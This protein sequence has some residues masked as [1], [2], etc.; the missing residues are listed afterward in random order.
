MNDCHRA[1]Y[2]GMR[3]LMTVAASIIVLIAQG[4]TV[5]PDTI[6]REEGTVVVNHVSPAV[7]ARYPEYV[8]FLRREHLDSTLDYAGTDLVPIIF[9]RDHTD[10]ILPNESLDSIVRVVNR[11]LADKNV[12]LA[13]VW[14][15]GAASPEGPEAHNVWLGKMR[16]K[17][18][19]DYLKT[20]TSLPDSLIRVENLTEDWRTPLKLMRE[21]DFPHKQRVLDIWTG[22][23]SNGR[24]KREIM[25]IDNGATWHYL[26]DH[27][28]RPSRNARMVIVCA[29]TDSIVTYHPQEA[30]VT[31]E[32]DLRPV[33]PMPLSEIVSQMLPVYRRQFVALKTNLA[34]LG[35]LV[36]NLGV[37]FSFGRGFSLD[38]P[39]Y[40]S[41]YD[42]TSKF[43]VRVLGTQ[44]ELRYWLK[45]DRP[46]EGHFVGLNGTI[47]GFNISFPET[48]RFQD[49]EHALWG[50]GVSY[51]YALDLG[52]NKR[53]GLE[54]NIGFGY[55]NYR[56]DTFLNV[57]NGKLLRTQ[58][59]DY[60]GVTRVGVSLTYK[61]WRHKLAK[62]KNVNRES[63]L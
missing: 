48:D 55:M 38:L 7:S 10:L 58:K 27:P 50:A 47:S 30:V 52:R 23:I 5:V 22:E 36:A 11:I 15:G 3:Y 24:R 2:R 51:G 14:I 63:R 1:S 62:W 20:H 45:R 61:W 9:K 13:Y 33:D 53:W 46:G 28:F 31:V 4:R 17:R 57:D 43:R 8:T 19:Y 54:F 29:A 35:L 56:Y 44:P 39:F 12:R 40:Y 16:A 41:P 37:E 60:W 18:L 34:A 6:H 25:A 21:H 59:K 32:K 49:P 42:I 26:I